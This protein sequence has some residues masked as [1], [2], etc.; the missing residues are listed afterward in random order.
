M[1]RYMLKKKVADGS[2]RIKLFPTKD[3]AREEMKNQYYEMFGAGP[4]Y[5]GSNESEME[6][7][8]EMSYLL[9]DEAHIYDECTWNI[10]EICDSPLKR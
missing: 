2:T 9:E 10:L 4:S 1:A 7:R 8:H 6:A 3:E 5:N